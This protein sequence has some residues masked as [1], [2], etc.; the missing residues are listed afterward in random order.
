MHEALRRLPSR[1]EKCFEALCVLDSEGP[2]PVSL[3]ALA[4][5]V[6]FRKPHCDSKVGVTRQFHTCTLTRIADC[7]PILRAA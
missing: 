5:S 3:A 1:V 2:P 4:F 6:F 7:A